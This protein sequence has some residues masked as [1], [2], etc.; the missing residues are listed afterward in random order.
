MLRPQGG[1]FRG[2]ASAI[3]VR[4]RIRGQPLITF[5]SFRKQRT[6]V[7][8]SGCFR[9][10]IRFKVHSAPKV[11]CKFSIIYII[12]TCGSETIVRMLPPSTLPR[13]FHVSLVVSVVS[14]SS[15]PA[16]NTQVGLSQSGLYFTSRPVDDCFL[17]YVDERGMRRTRVTVG[18][19]ALPPALED[20]VT[21][22]ACK[23]CLARNFSNTRKYTRIHGLLGIRMPYFLCLLG[24]RSSFSETGL[25][26]ASMRGAN[27]H[28]SY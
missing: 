28:S 8:L 2:T 12:Y 13:V 25:V 7:R 6:V 5:V 22:M 11:V 27:M 23:R 21:V 19:S 1:I 9:G 20:A 16:N 3:R 18:A 15:I 4:L 26:H 14:I 24:M 17:I 10:C